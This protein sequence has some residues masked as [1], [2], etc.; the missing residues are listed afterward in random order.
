VTIFT[1]RA[2]CVLQI[3]RL[4]QTVLDQKL[5]NKIVVGGHSFPY[6]N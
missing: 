1:G 6:Y 2:A 3:G 4:D 5:K